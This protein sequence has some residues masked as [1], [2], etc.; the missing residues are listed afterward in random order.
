M[1]TAQEPL[2]FLDEF[3]E[4]VCRAR[5]AAQLS[6]QELADRVGLTRTSIINIE[7]GRQTVNVIHLSHM[8]VALRASIDELVPSLKPAS[9][10][11]SGLDDKTKKWI[12][13]VLDLDVAELDILPNVGVSGEELALGG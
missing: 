11:P 5:K 12:A 13:R 2:S 1:T 3:G 4:R 9:S 6:Q 8:A 10:I 7:K